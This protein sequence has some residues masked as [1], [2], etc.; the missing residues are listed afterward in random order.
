MKLC[1]LF[2]GENERIHP[3]RG[4]MNP[5]FNINNWDTTLFNDLKA[6]G[7][8]YDIVFHTYNSNCLEMLTSLL[9]PKYIEINPSVSQVTNC[10]L[11]ADWI[12][13]YKDAYDR[14]II[15]RFDIL[16]RIKITEWPKWN[17]HG[18]FIV[19][20]EK[21][22]LDERLGTD[23]VFIADKDSV[24][25]LAAALR[26]TRRQAH[27]VLQYFYINDIPFHLMYNEIYLID[28]HP[29]YLIVGLEPPP[30]FSKPFEGV[31]IPS[32]LSYSQT[33]SELIKKNGADLNTEHCCIHVET[34]ESIVDK[35]P[36][37]YYLYT[38]FNSISF[39]SPY[40]DDLKKIFSKKRFLYNTD[41]VPT[42]S[43]NI[44]TFNLT[45]Q[46]KND[47]API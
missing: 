27:Q 37:I 6:A 10:K 45:R 31:P 19:N 23:F 44:D 17:E 4:Y 46:E 14:F 40:I 25:D 47:F 11:V 34:K 8:T 38:V 22:W 18:L 24:E 26:Y 28:N 3:V 9:V 33:Y 42:Y 36:E 32:M 15:L 2:R 5:C 39:D 13:A 12:S 20:R 16:Y 43:L 30:D 41:K 7:H 29:L 35:I 1:I 21:H